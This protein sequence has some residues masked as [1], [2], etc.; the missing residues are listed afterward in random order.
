MKC[1]ECGADLRR[2]VTDLPFKR[3]ARSIAIL[4]DLP[5]LQCENCSQFLIEDSTM[6]RIDKLLNGIDQSAEL[7]ILPY[8]GT[9]PQTAQA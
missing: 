8:R 3:G 6:E 7:E 4:R 1:H 9:L 5:V 2:V